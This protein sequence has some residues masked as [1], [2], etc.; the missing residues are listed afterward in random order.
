MD[1]MSVEDF[2][3]FMMN[4]INSESMYIADYFDKLDLEDYTKKSF[5]ENY[6]KVHRK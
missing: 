6:R 5:E 3:F 4:Y 1:N 2:N